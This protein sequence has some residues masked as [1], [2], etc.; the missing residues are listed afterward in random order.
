MAKWVLAAAVFVVCFAVYIVAVWAKLTMAY[1]N[2]PHTPM[3]MFP[4]PC[5]HGM[6]RKEDCISFGGV[7]YCARCWKA[8]WKD[9][10][11]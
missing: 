2:A 11:R 7:L 4:P 8:R 10:A 5:T 6:M 9:A 3:I 1:R